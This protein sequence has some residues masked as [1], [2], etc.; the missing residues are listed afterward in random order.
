MNVGTVSVPARPPRVALALAGAL[1][2]A[3]VVA[4]VI[5]LV[6]A[7]GSCAT[8]QGPWKFVAPAGI[9]GYGVLIAVG[10]L[11]PHR[12]FPVGSAIAAA[13]HTVLVGAMA[14]LG[15]LCPICIVAAALALA[16]FL[17]MLLRC[18]FRARM[19]SFVYVPAVLLASG[20]TAWALAHEE[21]L[22]NERQAFVRAIHESRLSAGRESILTIQVFEQDHC[23]YCRD[24]RELYLPRLERDFSDRVRVRFLPA[25]A[26]AWVRRTPT[27]VIEG[28][29][30]YEGLPEQYS[31][32]RAAVE[33]ALSSGK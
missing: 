33:R 30:V 13:V 25:T 31:E 16:L 10:F 7:C 19:I 17:V 5:Q 15:K 4:A 14:V 27:I 23:S 26:T 1:L 11:S 29:P 9:I 8:R 24:F 28:G 22:E 6:G 12:L 32:L 3:S 21:A 20:P 18:R 2:L